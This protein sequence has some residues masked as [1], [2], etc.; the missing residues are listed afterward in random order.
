M[1]KQLTF[2]LIRHGR[3]EWND[4]GLLQG[5]GDSPLTKEGIKGAIATGKA[6][7][8]I[9]F[10]MA[11]SSCLKRT[12]DTAKYIIGSRQIP[13]FQH[14][15]L[16]EHFFG[17]WEG[18]QIDTLRNLDE[19][20]QMQ[21]SPADYQALTNNGETYQTLAKRSMNA[22]N[23]IIQIN[24]QGNILVISHGHTLRMLIALMNGA[25]WQQHR[26][27]KYCQP[28]RNT[29]INVVHYVQNDHEKTG[30]FIVETINEMAH[31]G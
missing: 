24:D 20:K 2:Y 8:A 5:T 18:V 30:R 4:L 7:N 23:H 19:F 21:N 1:K 9:N 22:I 16:N 17:S 28:I 15:D 6:L 13:L 12:I 29:A 31:L 26:D 10:T 3:T 25:S 27:E 14:Q 11:F